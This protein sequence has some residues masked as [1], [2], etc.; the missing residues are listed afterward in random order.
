MEEKQKLAQ[1]KKAEQEAY[2]RKMNE[3]IANYNPFGRG[4]AGAPMKDQTGNV[5]G[6]LQC[7]FCLKY[8]SVSR[9][10]CD[11]CLDSRP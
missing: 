3:E 5:V 10:E 1:A 11:H 2:D 7:D 6:R 4:G 9:D 8:I